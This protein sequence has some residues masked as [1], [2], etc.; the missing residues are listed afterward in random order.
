MLTQP[1]DHS[2]SLRLIGQLVVKS[3]D[4]RLDSGIVKLW[5]QM[6]RDPRVVAFRARAEAETQRKRR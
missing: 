5:F 2:A 4:K 6:S 1:V 3:L